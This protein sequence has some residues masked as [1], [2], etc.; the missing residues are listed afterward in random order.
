MR[1]LWLGRRTP[2]AP[3]GRPRHGEVRT[4][5]QVQVRTRGVCAGV[6][7]DWP[8]CSSLDSDWLVTSPRAERTPLQLHPRSHTPVGLAGCSGGRWVASLGPTLTPGHTYGW[9]PWHDTQEEPRSACKNSPM[10]HRC[11]ETGARNGCK[12][13][14]NIKTILFPARVRH[15]PPRENTYTAPILEQETG[16]EW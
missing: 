13:E 7:P 1:Y 10:F 4:T 2:E 15:K 9:E 16:S 12:G 8:A 6:Y 14:R 11:G 5:S 3:L